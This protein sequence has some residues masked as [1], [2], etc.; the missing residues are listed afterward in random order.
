M[1]RRVYGALVA[2]LLGFGVGVGVLLDRGGPDADTSSDAVRRSRAVQVHSMRPDLS[3]EQV[4]AL[5]SASD[6]HRASNVDR[7][8]DD[9]GAEIRRRFA[10]ATFT[11]AER[12]AFFEVNRHVFGDRTYEESAWTV[13]QLLRIRAVREGLG[14]E[15]SSPYYGAALR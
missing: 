14:I 5:L 3:R 15:R 9:L 10:V 1:K 11:E 12:R 2:G 7:G 4:D 6:V 13:D 8:E